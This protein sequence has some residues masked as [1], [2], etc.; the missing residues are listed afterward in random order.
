MYVLK[1]NQRSTTKGGV[2]LKDALIISRSHEEYLMLIT[3]FE[4]YNKRARRR[5]VTTY[6]PLTDLV[7]LQVDVWMIYVQYRYEVTSDWEQ[8]IIDLVE[9]ITISKHYKKIF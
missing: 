1:L 9:G 4:N 8:D 2:Y 7:P 3:T 6:M 5:R